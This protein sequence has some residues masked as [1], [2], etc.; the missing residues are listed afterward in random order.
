MNLRNLICLVLLLSF[1]S[2]GALSCGKKAPPRPPDEA[3]YKV[4]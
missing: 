2:L 4:P 1:I 3:S